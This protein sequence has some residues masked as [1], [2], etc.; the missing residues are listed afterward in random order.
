MGIIRFDEEPARVCKIGPS[1]VVA[2]EAEHLVR[3]NALAEAA[4][5][6]A[7]FP[8]VQGVRT[9]G[10]RTALVME[11][12]EDRQLE[13]RVFADTAGWVLAGT[14]LEA[15]RPFL[16]A[17]GGVY[18]VSQAPGLSPVATYLAGDRVRV[19]SQH[20]LV[21]TTLEALLPGLALSDL[22]DR[23]VLLP[24]G[25]RLPSLRELLGWLESPSAPGAPALSTQ[26]H[27][28]VHLKNMLHHHDGRPAL[29]DPRLV[30]DGTV[31]DEGRGDPIFDMGSL[32][33]SLRPMTAVLNAV[34]TADMAALGECDSATRLDGILDLTGLA[35]HFRLDDALGEVL[36]EMQRFLPDWALGDRR[37]AACVAAGNALLG[38]LKYPDAL[39][40][41]TAFLT[42]FGYAVWFLDL[43]RTG[44]VGRA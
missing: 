42:V 9:L 12:L 20:P 13:R 38:W 37:P 21:A 15:L 10:D 29:I 14:C 19:L 35:D 4:G 3:V 18:D 33:H 17:L 28:D 39:Q 23:E 30:W 41:R 2:P 22:V 1:V 11:A 26:I 7:V 36:E 34:G 32:L 44:V 43:A 31:S 8:D 24:G 16:S 27:G 6:S 5:Q 40:H 25:R